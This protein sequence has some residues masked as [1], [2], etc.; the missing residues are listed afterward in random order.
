MQLN[1][2]AIESYWI[3]WERPKLLTLPILKAVALLLAVYKEDDGSGATHVVVEDSNLDDENIC[4][5][6]DSPQAT[7][8]DKR[9]MLAMLLLDEDER[10]SAMVIA[11]VARNF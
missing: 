7:E 10:D 3:E 8:L 9:C 2:D 6:M 5:C 1:P 11:A 4:A